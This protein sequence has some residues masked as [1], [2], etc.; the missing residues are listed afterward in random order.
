MPT[1]ETNGIQT[2][3]EEYGD[4]PPVVFLHG[5]WGDHRLWAEQVRSLATDYRIIVYDLRGHGRTG[6]SE[7]DSYTMR[8]Y[9]EDLNALVT[10]LD[11]DRPAICG[12]SMGGMVALAYA[13]AYPDTIGALCTLGAETPEAQ[14]RGEWVERRAL[15]KLIDVLST[16]VDRDRLMAVMHRIDEWRYDPRGAG[17]MEEIERILRSHAEEFPKP[18][19]DESTKIRKAVESYP[20]ESIDY[21][22]IL[23]PSLI[24]YGEYEIPLIRRHAKYMEN[25]IPHAEASRIPNAGHVST[26]DSPEFVVESLRELLASSLERVSG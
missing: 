25:V 24:L 18:S 8:S 7:L 12:R 16:V 4:G 14:T 23:V 9:V 17:D 6:G 10:T 19:A 13:A 11:L 21:S 26:V 2:Y 20:S 1:A 22:S 15:P 5:A 3:Y